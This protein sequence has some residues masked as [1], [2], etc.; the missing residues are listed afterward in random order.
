M[1]QVEES[2]PL[3]G[4][5]TRH[6]AGSTLEETS[7]F[8]PIVVFNMYVHAC[9]ATVFVPLCRSTCLYGPFVSSLDFKTDLRA[10]NVFI[11]LKI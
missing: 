2:G 1:Q 9:V 3:M 7:C 5:D 10:S 11:Y 8:K 6:A 4:T